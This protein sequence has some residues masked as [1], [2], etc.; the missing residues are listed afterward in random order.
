MVDP[1]AERAFPGEREIEM[2]ILT[3]AIQ[4]HIYSLPPKQEIR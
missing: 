3:R 2:H 1:V 4:Q